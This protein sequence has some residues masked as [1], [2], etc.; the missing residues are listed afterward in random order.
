MYFTVASNPLFLK[1]SL[2]FSFINSYYNKYKK[3]NNIKEKYKRKL[4]GQEYRV[5]FEEEYQKLI[6]SN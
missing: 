5:I 3:E 6:L 2:I 1:Y 4:R